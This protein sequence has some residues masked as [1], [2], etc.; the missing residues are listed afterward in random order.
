MNSERWVEINGTKS[1]KVILKYE[2]C[3]LYIFSISV[4]WLTN[5]ITVMIM[6]KWFP[7]R[8]RSGSRMAELLLY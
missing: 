2:N 1:F 4:I 3:V 6:I 8:L 7:I 5:I